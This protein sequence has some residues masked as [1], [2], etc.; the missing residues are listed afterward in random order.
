MSDETAGEITPGPLPTLFSIGRVG[1]RSDAQLVELYLTGGKEAREFGFA[2][3]VERHGPMVLRL[4]RQILNDPDDADDAFQATFLVLARSSDAVRKRDSLAS[5]LHGVALRVSH[6]ARAD[7]ARRRFHERNRAQR[8]TRNLTRIDDNKVPE[9][10]EALHHHELECLPRR[11][12]EPVVLCHL[13]GLSTEAAARRLGCPLGTILS[14]LARGRARLRQ[15]LNR[16]GLAMSA[17]LLAIDETARPALTAV[18]PTLARAVIRSAIATSLGQQEASLIPANVALWTSG[19]RRAMIQTSLKSSAM[20][21]IAA[22]LLTNGVLVLL[23]SSAA[24]GPQTPANPT[25]E[26]AGAPAPK[27]LDTYPALRERSAVRKD[28]TWSPVPPAE[29]IRVLEMLIAKTKANRDAIRTWKG[30]YVFQASSLLKGTSIPPALMV[31]LKSVP[32]L[33]ES[34]FKVDFA[35]DTAAKSTYQDKETTRSQF[36]VASSGEPIEFMNVAIGDLRSIVTPSQILVFDVSAQDRPITPVPPRLP[37]RK[38]RWATK[39]APEERHRVADSDPAN[40]FTIGGPVMAWDE[41]EDYASALK[42]QRGSG[43]AAEMARQLT[44]SQAESPSGSWYWVQ[45]RVDGPNGGK[46]G[47]LTSVW[48]PEAGYNPVIRFFSWDRPDGPPGSITQWTWKPVDGVYIPASYRFASI[49]PDGTVADRKT[50]TL[51]R[52]ELNHPLGANPFDYEALGLGDGDI[53]LDST[54][55]RYYVLNHGELMDPYGPAIP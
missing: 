25:P 2:T 4:C 12:R 9:I 33:S 18:P 48:S 15:G 23:A 31:R 20:T 32:V 35:V 10:G 3:L 14:R 30:A 34:D 36:R 17:G 53:V 19:V 27:K 28:L 21:M 43:R 47:Y 38:P 49:N 39:F 7:A 22:A 13:Q 45:V 50:A 42:G 37:K 29:S 11:F 54:T 55:Q 8:A 46:S 40:V 44:L 41:L 26:P 51:D 6:R 52:C 1:D 5:W 24:S 16:R